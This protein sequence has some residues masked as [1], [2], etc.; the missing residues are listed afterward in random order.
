MKTYKVTGYCLVPNKVEIVVNAR[1]ADHAKQ[2]AKHKFKES[3]RAVI[4]GNSQDD[5]AAF[6]FEPHAPEEISPA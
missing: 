6:D 5:S 4:V 2:L 1:D 3:P